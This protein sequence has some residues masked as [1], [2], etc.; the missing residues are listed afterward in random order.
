MTPSV[1]SL[2]PGV[3]RALKKGLARA[4]PPRRLRKNFVALD[5]AAQDELRAQILRTLKAAD[6]EWFSPAYCSTEAGRREIEDEV[7][8]R[9]ARIRTSFVPWFDRA[10]RL[11]GKRVLEVGCGTGVLSVAL[12]EQGAEVVGIDVLGDCLDAAGRRCAL[13]GVKADFFRAD[14]AKLDDVLGN[15]TF[16]MIVF[17][18]S[19]EHMTFDER[20]ISMRTTWEAL[21]P[22]GFWCLNETPNRLWFMDRHTSHLPFFHWL[23]DELAYRYAGHSAREPFRR[24]YGSKTPAPGTLVDF[25]RRGRGL[26]YHEFALALKPPEDLDVVSSFS[27][28]E[29]KR[30]LLKALLWSLT[31]EGRY[32][33]LLARLGPRIHPGFYH[34]WLNLIIRK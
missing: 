23:P 21:P 5:A 33:A 28:Y 16:D 18:A 26:S 34:P 22:G 29:R 32:E 31:L 10:I 15:R 3:T 27:L 12:A 11:N 8:G 19:L 17:A 9:L 1:N 30:N 2:P 20:M 7:S 25:L 6:P 24:I 14:A 4:A 13:H